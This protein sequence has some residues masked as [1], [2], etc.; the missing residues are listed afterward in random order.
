MPWSPTNGVKIR[1]WFTSSN[2]SGAMSTC[3]GTI[4]SP[5]RVR[6]RRGRRLARLL[7]HGALLDADQRLAGLSV[8]DVGPA[9]LADLRKPF[10]HRA[11]DAHVEQHDGIRRVVIPEVVMN[12]LEVPAVLAGASLDRNDRRREQVVAGAH[13][14]VEIGARIAGREIDQPELGVDGRR[15][16][17][18]RAAVH[19]HLVV[20][21]PGVVAELAGA[22][23]RVERPEQLAVVGVVRFDAAAHADL[24]AREARDHHAVV[25][26]R[27]A[28]DRKP[29]L[30]ALGLDRTR[31]PCPFVDRA[32]RGGRRAS[33]DEDL[34]VADA[35]TA[36]RPA[37]A[38]RRDLG[39]RC[40]RYCQRISPVSTDSANTSSAPVMT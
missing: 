20:L 31:L 22:R 17:H 5:T 35:D 8:E 34:A 10:A 6:L 30:P 2:P 19:P 7:R 24:G 3:C 18:R 28:R 15:L 29:F 4:A 25:V 13:G 27:R 40:A 38:H 37:A 33:A 9:R 36:T 23:D 14:A 16:P 32:Q 26:E 21:R 1:P 12:L 39:S 11:A